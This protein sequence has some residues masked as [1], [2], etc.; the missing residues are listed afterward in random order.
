MNRY[1]VY[2]HCYVDTNEIFYI[3]KGTGNRLNSKNRSA[4]WK[5][6]SSRGYYSLIVKDNL[7]EN[8]AIDFENELLSVFDTTCNILKK[9]HKVKKI[10][11][12][13]VNSILSYDE[14]SPTF[15]RYK[16][17]RANGAIK[18]GSV[19]GSFD[20]SGYGQVYIKDRL[21]KIHRVIYCLFL[22]EDLDCN[23]LI[24]H[25]DRNKSNNRIDNLRLTDS[26]GNAKNVDWSKSKPT[27]TGE[28]AIS[29]RSESYRVLWTEGNKRQKEKCFSFGERSKRTKE[30]A[31]ELAIAFRNSLI[32]SGFIKL[33]TLPPSQ[34][35]NPLKT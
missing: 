14:S 1:Y 13:F 26:S 35:G 23:L 32:E 10:D 12:N 29:L 6:C 20:S 3:G 25:I 34:T 18:A 22:K 4:L 30:E 5:A 7:S 11:F 9:S 33:V 15:L 31:F 17:D 27:N 8:E 24:D 21:Y 2:C 16:V 19:A 28:R